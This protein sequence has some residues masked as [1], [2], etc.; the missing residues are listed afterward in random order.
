MGRR[1]VYRHGVLI[2]LSHPLA[3]ALALAPA[4]ADALRSYLLQARQE[5]ATRLC[6]RL[7]PLEP[8]T[9]PDGT[10]TPASR[11]GKRQEKPSKWWMAF[12]KRK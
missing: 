11:A 6:D 4:R 1:H 3:L 9:Q 5:L 10:P 2:S 12:Q 7:Y 8:A